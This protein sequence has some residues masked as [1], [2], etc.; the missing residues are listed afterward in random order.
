MRAPGRSPGII[1]VAKTRWALRESE[2]PTTRVT[3]A[4]WMLLAIATAGP[5]R[6]TGGGRNS[7]GSMGAGAL[8]VLLVNAAPSLVTWTK[9]TK[10]P[11]QIE[12]IRG[13]G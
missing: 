8:R 5:R 13:G 3:F 4:S 2:A 7:G 9:M 12:V 10:W 11:R 6:S 1:S